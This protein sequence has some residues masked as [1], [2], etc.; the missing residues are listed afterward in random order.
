MT[1]AEIFLALGILSMLLPEL[2][3]AA[4]P[5]DADPFTAKNVAKALASFVRTVIS[6]HSPYDRFVY[7]GE[8]DALSA[9]AVR[10]LTLF[11]GT[12]RTPS[13]SWRL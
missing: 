10:G 11:F 6:G 2:F 9:S 5:Q 7:G 3:T 12:N 1:L 13:L 4:Y 8:R